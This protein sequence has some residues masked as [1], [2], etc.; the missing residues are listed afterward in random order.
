[1]PAKRTFFSSPLSPL[2]RNKSCK[3][4]EVVNGKPK[5]DIRLFDETGNVI[6]SDMCCV[7]PHKVFKHSFSNDQSFSSPVFNNPLFP[8]M[9]PVIIDW[10]GITKLIENL[11]ISAPGTDEITAQF[12]K[13]TVTH[14]SIILSKLLSSLWTV[15]CC[16]M[17]GRWGRWC[18]FKNKVTP[19][20][21]INYRPISLTSIPGKLLQHIIYSNL[22]LFLE[23]NNFFS[24]YQP[25]FP[26]TPFM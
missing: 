1:M 26:K 19:S 11:K 14:S 18:L 3:F 23:S 4:W 22:M 6:P 10:V 21:A 15:V 13:C 2:L 5:Q 25:W 24:K 9:D 20:C 17:T 7:A 16:P 8:T 12:L